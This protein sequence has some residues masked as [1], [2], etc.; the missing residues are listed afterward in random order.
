MIFNMWFLWIFGRNIEDALGH[1]PYLVF[2]LTCGFAAALAQIVCRSELAGSNGGRQR[3][4][5]GSD[6]RIL[7]SVSTGA[8][9]D[10]GSLLCSSSFSGCRPGRCWATGSCLQF[11][12]GVGTA[13]VAPEQERQAGLRSGPMWEALWREFAGAAV[14]FRTRRYRYGY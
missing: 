14:P 3:R 11:L 10:A 7:C 13:L 1:F 2:Y 4:D 12:S 5:C 8:G 6:G 9:A